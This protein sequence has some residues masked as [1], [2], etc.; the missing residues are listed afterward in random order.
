MKRKE[1]VLDSAINDMERHWTDW[2]L[3]LK[4]MVPEFFQIPA[5]H[6]ACQNP[7]QQ[8]RRLLFP[9]FPSVLGILARLWLRAEA[10]GQFSSCSASPQAMDGLILHSSV[11]RNNSLTLGLI[12]ISHF[13]NMFGTGRSCQQKLWSLV[14]HPPT[15]HE[16]KAAVSFTSN[17]CGG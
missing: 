3:W 11:I 14:P 6:N 7:A 8:G 9:C 1:T 2:G 10:A 12:N 4:Q 17:L 15:G 5:G 16:N 13:N